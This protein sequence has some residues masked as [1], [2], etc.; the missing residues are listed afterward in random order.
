MEKDK[1]NDHS[2]SIDSLRNRISRIDEKIVE[3][4]DE[5]MSCVQEVARFKKRVQ[6][7]VLCT[8]KRKGNI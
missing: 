1:E 5:R 3:L 4:L 2:V 8:G 7:N 6:F